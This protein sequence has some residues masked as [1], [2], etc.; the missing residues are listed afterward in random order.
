M[1]HELLDLTAIDGGGDGKVDADGMVDVT[2]TSTTTTH[3]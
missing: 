1:R 2:T 3:S